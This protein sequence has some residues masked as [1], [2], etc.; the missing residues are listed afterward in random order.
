MKSQNARQNKKYRVSHISQKPC[1]LKTSLPRGLH[2][3]TCFFIK[4]G[5]MDH[6]PDGIRMSAQSSSLLPS[7]S[8]DLRG[9]YS[10]AILLSL[11]LA[12]LLMPSDVLARKYTRSS[13]PRIQLSQRDHVTDQDFQTLLDHLMRNGSFSSSSTG[14]S[15]SS[16]SDS[17]NSSLEQFRRDGLELKHAERERARNL[18]RAQANLRRAHA[19]LITEIKPEGKEINTDEFEFF[20][21]S[22]GEYGDT[23]RLKPTGFSAFLN[24]HLPTDSS[25]ER[26][27]AE[28][29][30]KIFAAAM[31][32]YKKSTAEIKYLRGKLDYE[33]SRVLACFQDFPSDRDQAQFIRQIIEKNP[34]LDL[35]RDFKEKY[36][37][38]AL[39]RKESLARRSGRAPV[40]YSAFLCEREPQGTPMNS[41]YQNQNIRDVVQ[42]SGAA[43]QRSGSRSYF[44]KQVEDDD[45][46]R[47]I[48]LSDLGSPD[49]DQDDAQ[50][51]SLGSLR[52]D[53]DLR[54]T[55]RTSQ[56]Q[57]PLTVQYILAQISR[58]LT[59]ECDGERSRVARLECENRK[60]KALI[61]E[62]YKEDRSMS[63]RA[64]RDRQKAMT[65]TVKGGGSVRTPSLERSRKSSPRASQKAVFFRDDESEER[66]VA[67]A[68]ADAP[69][70]GFKLELPGQ[71][72]AIIG[73]QSYTIDWPD[74]TKSNPSSDADAVKILRTKVNARNSG[75]P[76]DFKIDLNQHGVYQVGDSFK[77]GS[78]K[79]LLE[80]FQKKYEAERSYLESNSKIQDFLT[81]N[82]YKA[83]KEELV[84]LKNKVDPAIL[85][86]P[87]MKDRIELLEDLIRLNLP[88]PDSASLVRSK[89][90]IFSFLGKGADSPSPQSP[91]SPSRFSFGSFSFNRFRG[92]SH[93]SSLSDADGGDSDTDGGHDEESDSSAR[94]SLLPGKQRSGKQPASSLGSSPKSTAHGSSS[95]APQSA[96]VSVSSEPA[97]SEKAQ[98]FTKI[99]KKLQDQ[100][101]S[102]QGI[103]GIQAQAQVYATE[104]ESLSSPV[105]GQE[106]NEVMRINQEAFSKMNS[107][108]EKQIQE[109][110]SGQNLLQVMK[111][112]GLSF[113]ERKRVNSELQSLLKK[114]RELSGAM[115]LYL[116][117]VTAQ[118][119]LGAAQRVPSA[120]IADQRKRL[121]EAKV[122]IR[123]ALKDLES[124][125][126]NAQIKAVNDEVGSLLPTD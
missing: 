112:H 41:F 30:R 49:E 62:S 83:V 75:W 55:R 78:Q 8:L 44:M 90:S 124:P 33:R 20:S 113:D 95:V 51:T 43:A 81:L 117:I 104:L 28:S 110:F 121:E 36:S 125:T 74:G 73:R 64:Q 108:R 82:N 2:S 99:C 115:T 26:A 4:E 37:S 53:V 120:T 32:S 29:A 126:F 15:L 122:K 116:M 84:R 91:S 11:M 12:Q 42:L 101:Y 65:S 61:A 92:G 102:S 60:M 45:D 52:R 85:E 9:A 96:S 13:S 103:S 6:A 47:G 35:P 31:T 67:E 123:G 63:S 10:R 5:A 69:P 16:D 38:S 40:D 39:E 89:S 86:E 22:E 114:P 58:H 57:E 77:T 79:A 72:S 17:L 88:E 50:V 56:R 3:P 70:A 59:K 80:Y 19:N 7:R 25:G 118:V 107:K 94:T 68:T 119:R 109:S 21:E 48:E 34:N 76:D 97:L 106:L 23:I 27:R 18:E 46:E 54:H 105:S 71:F 98:S 1:L 93:Y 14:L 87:K 24:R 66:G 100:V 111:K